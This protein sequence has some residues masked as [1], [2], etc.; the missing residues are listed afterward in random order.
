[1]A[2]SRLFFSNRKQ[3]R[4]KRFVSLY[5]H[6]FHRSLDDCA[7]IPVPLR[8]RLAAFAFLTKRL[9]SLL[10]LPPLPHSAGIK[11]RAHLCEIPPLGT[12]TRIIFS[13]STYCAKARNVPRFDEHSPKLNLFTSNKFHRQQRLSLNIEIAYLFELHSFKKIDF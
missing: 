13:L 11:N 9:E 10:R 4:K 3:S 6:S 5:G 1:M 2:F 7:L 8:D 12:V